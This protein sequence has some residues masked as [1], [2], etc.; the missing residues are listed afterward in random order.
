MW[1]KYDSFNKVTLIYLNETFSLLNWYS[2][3]TFQWYFW[4]LLE[5]LLH[6]KNRGKRIKYKD[7]IYFGI[8]FCIASFLFK[9][10]VF[11]VSCQSQFQSKKPPSQIFLIFLTPFMTPCSSCLNPCYDHLSPFSLSLSLISFFSF[12]FPGPL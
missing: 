1:L 10:S 12:Q 5:W 7:D 2:E 3:L 11:L 8:V 6:Y 9:K 4:R